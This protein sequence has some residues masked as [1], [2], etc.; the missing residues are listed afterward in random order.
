MSSIESC[1]RKCWFV[2]EQRERLV[3]CL[4]SKDAWIRLLRAGQ[5]NGLF[6]LREVSIM[7]G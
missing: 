3:L 4:G 2:R 5:L 7:F 1:L 6:F